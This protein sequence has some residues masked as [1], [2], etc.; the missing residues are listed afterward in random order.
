LNFTEPSEFL[1]G[2]IF[3]V[4]LGVLVLKITHVKVA[5]LGL[6]NS[7]AMRLVTICSELGGK[8]EFMTISVTVPNNGSE[9][10]IRESA[11]AKAK[12]FARHFAELPLAL[13]PQASVRFDR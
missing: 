5:Q 6:S 3:C 8:N 11:I 10:E 13:F 2:R 9:N 7:R 4:T 1:W 12:D